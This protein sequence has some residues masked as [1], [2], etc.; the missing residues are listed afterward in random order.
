MKKLLST[1][2]I[3]CSVLLTQAQTGDKFTETMTKTLADMDTVKTGDGMMGFANKFERIALAEKTQWLPFYYAS[4][5]RTTAAF[6]YNDATK[7]DAMMDVAEKHCKV[8]DSLSPTNSEIMVLQSMILSGR[9][10]VD[11]MSRGQMYGMQ[12][13]MYMQKAMTVDPTNPRAYFMM[14]QSLFFTP[15]Q[16]GGGQESGC[17][18]MQTAKDLYATHVPKSPIH[19]SWGE[20]QVDEM[21]LKCPKNDTEN[22]PETPEKE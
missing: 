9:I 15:P 17:A 7:F 18:M 4:L 8:A 13:M 11:P 3:A 19:P 2:F 12:A 1:L 16:F 22:T 20:D 5:C 10:M 14:G 6:M 21:L